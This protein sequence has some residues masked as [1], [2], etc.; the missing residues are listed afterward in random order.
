MIYH[1][2][3]S[4]DCLWH[5]ILRGKQKEEKTQTSTKWFHI[6]IDQIN[7]II[8]WL[9]RPQLFFL[10]Q[11]NFWWRQWIGSKAVIPSWNIYYL[12]DLVFFICAER[13]TSE[14][15]LICLIYSLLGQ[16]RS[17]KTSSQWKK[18]LVHLWKNSFYNSCSCPVLKIIDTDLQMTTLD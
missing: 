12:N 16:G 9:I 4:D 6:F 5:L 18:C 10:C 17:G 14:N 3:Q 1:P 7:N 8:F 15:S 2:T 11:I 13:S